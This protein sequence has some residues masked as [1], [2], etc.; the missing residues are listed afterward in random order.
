MESLLE[1]TSAILITK[2][3][4]Y[5]QEIIDSLPKFAETYIIT[6]CENVYQRYV[7]CN[8]AKTQYIY[9]QDDDCITDIRKLLEEFEKDPYH[10]TCAMKKHHLDYYKDSK[11][12]LVGWGAIF[13]A[14]L[15]SNMNVYF[16]K[17]PL[18]EIAS[19]EA[20]RIFTYMNYPQKRLLIHIKDLPFYNDGNRMS[21]RT[22]HF[23]ELKKIE[24][25]LKTL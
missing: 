1:K 3:S 18:D 5:P 10:L 7:S 23:E 8:L 2:E 21:N 17:Y 14:S 22:N 19:N 16:R 6:R 20:D 25:R 9:V 11:I 15:L 12:C 24:E 4:S 13:P